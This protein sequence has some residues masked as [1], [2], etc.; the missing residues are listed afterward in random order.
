MRENKT[1]IINNV[2]DNKNIQETLFFSIAK[3]TI[4]NRK[5]VANS[6]HNLKKLSLNNI[7][8]SLI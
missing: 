7:L 6:F 1:T 4:T 5:T 2:K 3:N 8:P